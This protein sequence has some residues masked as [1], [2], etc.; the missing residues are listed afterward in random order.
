MA[1][2]IVVLYL[3]RSLKIG[4]LMYI[5]LLRLDLLRTYVCMPSGD[6]GTIRRPQKVRN[7]QYSSM[8]IQCVY[9]LAIHDMT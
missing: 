2:E 6:T 1:G 3:W 7:D 8:C 5:V 9:S 4:F